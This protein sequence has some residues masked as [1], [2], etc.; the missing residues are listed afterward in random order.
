MAI[1]ACRHHYFYFSRRAFQL[2]SLGT[3]FLS[4]GCVQ[5][6]EFHFALPSPMPQAQSRRRLIR[7]SPPEDDFVEMPY[8]HRG[9]ATCHVQLPL[10]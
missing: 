10:S 6:P 2:H 1:F 3:L 7:F 8:M 4:L 9:S 5:S